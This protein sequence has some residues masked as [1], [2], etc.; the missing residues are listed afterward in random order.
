MNILI[1][2]SHIFN[3]QNPGKKVS[4]HSSWT[5]NLRF[6]HRSIGCPNSTSCRGVN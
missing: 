1:E 3:T 2:P 4:I 6:I 5:R